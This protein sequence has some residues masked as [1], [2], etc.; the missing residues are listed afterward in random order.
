M[1]LAR[2]W[3][4]PIDSQSIFLASMHHIRGMYPIFSYQ[5]LSMTLF[6]QLMVFE[7]FEV[8]GHKQ[9]SSCHHWLLT[10]W[11]CHVM[12]LK[13]FGCYNAL[14]SPSSVVISWTCCLPSVDSFKPCSVQPMRPPPLPFIL[15][16][17][18]C[19]L[20]FWICI[21]LWLCIIHVSYTVLYSNKYFFKNQPWDIWRESLTLLR[22]YETKTE[23][24]HGF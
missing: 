11:R 7:I 15:C 21:L 9:R 22:T 14:A 3:Y 20:W 18:W 13:R 1:A 23:N 2:D 17:C 5:G 19:F 4:N 8:V 10:L 12:P 24:K 16:T 6:F